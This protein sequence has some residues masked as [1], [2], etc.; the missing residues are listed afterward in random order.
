MLAKSVKPS[1]HKKK[2]KHRRIEHKSRRVI[3]KKAATGENIAA[4]C[5]L[6]AEV[7]L[8]YGLEAAH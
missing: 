1:T 8:I 6:S 4:T 2:K 5:E 3:A 7:T